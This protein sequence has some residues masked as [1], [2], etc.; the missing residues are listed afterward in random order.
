M[1]DAAE[2]LTEARAALLQARTAEEVASA[3]YALAEALMLI[4]LAE[5]F[6]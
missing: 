5:A 2:Y 3:R 6:A 4:V 1:N